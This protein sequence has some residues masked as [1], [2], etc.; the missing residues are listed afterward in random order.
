MVQEQ[1]ASNKIINTEAGAL[2]VEVNISEGSKN[3]GC[4]TENSLNSFKLGQTLS[5]PFTLPF[6]L[7]L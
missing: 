1:I 2:V 3:E 5:I 4:V 7:C 6:F